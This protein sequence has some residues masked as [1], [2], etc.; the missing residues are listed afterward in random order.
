MSGALPLPEITT[1]GFPC[2]LFCSPTISQHLWQYREARGS[3][4]A[5]GST[6]P[7]R[8]RV[9]TKIHRALGNA[10]EDTKVSL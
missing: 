7:C 5:I 6:Q 10:Q 1:P 9:N 2:T 3:E 8:E 4:K